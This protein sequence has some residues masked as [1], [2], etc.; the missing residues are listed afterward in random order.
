MPS[1]KKH[2]HNIYLKGDNMRRKKPLVFAH[3]GASAYAPENTLSAFDLAVQQGCDGIELDV[4]LSLDKKLIV[5]HDEHIE[6]TTNGKGLVQDLT[7]EELKEYDAGSWFNETFKG[8]KIPLLEEVFELVPPH[9]LINVEIKN[10]PSFYEGIEHELCQI[11]RKYKREE[12]LVVS[13]FDH[14]SLLE[15][16][17]IC[18]EVKIGLLYVS[19]LFDHVKYAESIHVPVYSLH[20]KHDCIKRQDIKKAVQKGLYV[21]PWTVNNTEQMKEMV[22]YGFSGIM[23]DYPDK[24]KH[25]IDS[26]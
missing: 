13:S 5:I 8:E 22:T 2:S 6:K 20:P 15:V 1:E 4:H 17:R 11:I 14:Q 19:N 16:N 10:I 23:T 3:R 24:L 26:M 18:P 9:I 7:V 21:F 25:V 12:T